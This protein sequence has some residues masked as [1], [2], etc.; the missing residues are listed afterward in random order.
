MNL[1]FKCPSCGSSEFVSEPNQYDILVF[2][3]DGFTTQ[4]TQAVEEYKIYCREC[5]EEVD[6]LNSIKKIILK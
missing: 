3:K 4:S 5:S 2:T 1:R 6:T